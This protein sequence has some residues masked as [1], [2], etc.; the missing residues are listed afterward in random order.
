[1]SEKKNANTL[2]DEATDKA[3]KNVKGINFQESGSVLDQFNSEI[4][5]ASELASAKAR[6]KK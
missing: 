1:M 3:A 5:Q 6:Q 2:M 4:D